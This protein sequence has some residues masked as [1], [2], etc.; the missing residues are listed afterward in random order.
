MLPNYRFTYSCHIWL[1]I[2]L[3]FTLYIALHGHNHFISK[4]LFR[5]NIY[6]TKP[7]L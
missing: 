5:L 7:N 6:K 1:N 4:E 3:I 2:L